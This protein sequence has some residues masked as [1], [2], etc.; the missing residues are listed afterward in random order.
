MSGEEAEAKTQAVVE[1]PT[2]PDR[3][4]V[5]CGKG[6][7]GKRC[8]KCKASY[9][10]AA[11]QKL[12]WKEHRLFCGNLPE[13]GNPVSPA[14]RFDSDE[15][16]GRFA[17]AARQIERGELIFKQRMISGVCAF[18]G[19]GDAYKDFFPPGCH[20]GSERHKP[21]F[22]HEDAIIRNHM[23]K[24][25]FTADIVAKNFFLGH[26]AA[27]DR[28]GDVFLR[29]FR[30]NN[31]RIVDIFG[32]EMGAA[33]FGPGA[34]SLNHSCHANTDYVFGR[35]GYIY[36]FATR[37]IPKG[38]EVTASYFHQS[39]CDNLCAVA[40]RAYLRDILQVDCHCEEC[41]LTPCPPGC[42]HSKLMP[43]S[44]AAVEKAKKDVPEFFSPVKAT[45]G[46][47]D[48]ER[49]MVALSKAW[50]D[51]KLEFLKEDPMLMSMFANRIIGMC[52]TFGDSYRKLPSDFPVFLRSVGHAILTNFKP[53]LL[54][55]HASPTTIGLVAATVSMVQE[56]DGSNDT[57]R[58]K[59]IFGWMI[60]FFPE[61]F[62][63]RPWLEPHFKDLLNGAELLVPNFGKLLD[64]AYDV[65]KEGGAK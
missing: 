62:Y 58:Y 59:L 3:S 32:V 6:K 26:D 41:E 43:H 16:R 15:K 22:R 64:R 36:F 31:F 52:F 29:A 9:C 34:S 50:T 18:S 8:A 14:V 48:R 20:Y 4:C 37:P 35:G 60:H 10:D 46:G 2:P 1:S 44:L 25:G 39:T 24:K 63:L 11:C 61:L 57:Q 55:A 40:R 38:E 23:L 7:A 65:H 5:C 42:A 49:N 33:L 12:D 45:D 53:R 27:E 30:F 54:G 47:L 13:M 56:K 51:G 17:E 19:L 28:E 21:K